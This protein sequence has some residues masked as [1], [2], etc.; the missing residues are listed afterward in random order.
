VL[1]ISCHA[2]TGFRTHTLKRL[3]GGILK[4]H[5]DNFVGVHTVMNAYF[6]GRMRPQSVRIE[7]THGEEKDFRGAK[8]VR[9]TLRRHDVVL[10]V[11]VTGTPTTKAFVIEKC[12]RPALRAFFRKEL[13]KMAFDLYEGCPDPVSDEDE[14][15]VYLSKTRFCALLGIPCFGGDYNAG[16]VRCSEASIE[17]ATE[18]LI[19]LSRAFPRLCRQQGIRP[20]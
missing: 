1:V 4:G 13:R 10:V 6:S 20:T 3:R 18:A 12:A 11:D 17:A 16:P 14:V 19:R 15:D 2:D 7:L 5:L 8:E 9:R